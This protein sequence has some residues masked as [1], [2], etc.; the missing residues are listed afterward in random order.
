MRVASDQKMA[1]PQRA[2]I[3]L[4]ADGP[5]HFLPMLQSTARHTTRNIGHS[6]D[7]P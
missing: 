3:A 4:S 6:T 2:V 1:M 7:D 5:V